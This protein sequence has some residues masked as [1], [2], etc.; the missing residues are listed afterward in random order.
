MIKK[1]DKII[2]SYPGN[3]RTLSLSQIEA[4]DEFR[5]NVALG[6]KVDQNSYY[7]MENGKPYPNPQ[8][9]TSG[10]I[11][12]ILESFSARSKD[13][14]KNPS[15]TVT[16]KS[17]SFVNLIK[18]IPTNY[19]NYD[20]KLL[21]PE[22]FVQTYLG[23]EPV[24]RYLIKN[25]SSTGFSFRP[26]AFERLNTDPVDIEKQL[27]FAF[28]RG[29]EGR[30]NSK[31][32]EFVKRNN[33]IADEELFSVATAF[34]NP[35]VVMANI[36]FDKMVGYC[37]SHPYYRGCNILCPYDSDKAQ[38][39]D[40]L[41]G[42]CKDKYGKYQKCQDFA[43]K[44]KELVYLEIKKICSNMNDMT[45]RMICQSFFTKN[46]YDC[47]DNLCLTS[48]QIYE[49]LCKNSSDPRCKC[50]NHQQLIR[51]REEALKN[52]LDPAVKN[53]EKTINEAIKKYP[54]FADKL[55]KI[56]PEVIEKVREYFYYV[57]YGFLPVAAQCLISEC[58]D[59]ILPST[60]EC[61]LTTFISAFCFNSINI[62]NLMEGRITFSGNQ[63]CKIEIG[64]DCGPDK[65][66]GPGQKCVNGKCRR[67]CV[68]GKCLPGSECIGGVCQS[69]D[70]K[71]P[72]SFNW[73]YFLYGLLFF[74]IIFL[75][76]YN[77]NF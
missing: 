15:I 7:R 64:L 35:E 14:S 62:N 38:C 68:E 69:K 70:D 67:E 60:T 17:P 37:K 36:N 18:V 20:Y 42:F 63:S 75:I 71:E 22:I 32:Y 54:K 12:P 45:Q 26:E 19:E 5:N 3:E 28:E 56:K 74:L 57:S 4:Y 6:G 44:N 73:T 9:V 24:Y 25:F 21:S 58:R 11:R 53:T 51:G 30:L 10:D 43:E 66:C 77:L 47:K 16:L 34:T 13:K 50:I 31:G 33:G 27:K 61:K 76:F 41:S 46:A 8:N 52:L 72:S 40:F 39:K 2:I 49:D 23:Q 48:K 65:D 55:R 59:G 1:I 29:V